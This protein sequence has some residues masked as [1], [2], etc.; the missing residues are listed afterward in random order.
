[1]SDE[2]DIVDRLLMNEVMSE[3]NELIS[4]KETFKDIDFSSCNKDASCERSDTPHW[5]GDITIISREDRKRCGL[6]LDSYL[7]IKNIGTPNRFAC[8][9]DPVYLVYGWGTNTCDAIRDCINNII[10]WRANNKDLISQRLGDW[11]TF[12]N[13]KGSPLKFSI[14]SEFDGPV[15]SMKK[16][17]AKPLVDKTTGDILKELGLS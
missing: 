10:E 2:L 13:L 11:H 14:R 16:L 9:Y 6:P 15:K 17:T 12:I 1:M 8:V 5:G 3:V 7:V 4:N